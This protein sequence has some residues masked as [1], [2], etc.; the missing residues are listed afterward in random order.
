MA[1]VNVRRVYKLDAEENIELRGRVNLKMLIEG[2]CSDEDIEVI[3]TPTLEFTTAISQQAIG[4]SGWTPK[5]KPLVS[6]TWLSPRIHGAKL[7]GIVSGMKFKG[8]R[9][10]SSAR[11]GGRRLR[12]RPASSEPKHHAMHVDDGIAA[13]GDEIL[14]R[15]YSSG[16]FL[17]MLVS[18]D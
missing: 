6:D 18:H 8:E 11:S 13:S 5:M 7:L 9:Q 10:S 12:L 16:I 15:R 2:N 4:Y 3:G 14:D 1:E 17:S